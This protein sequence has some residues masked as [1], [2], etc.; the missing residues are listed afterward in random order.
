[1]IQWPFFIPKNVPFRLLR[2][3][4]PSSGGDKGGDL[5]G[6][7]S[8]CKRSTRPSTSAIRSSS[9]SIL[10]CSNI[11]FLLMAFSPLICSLQ[12]SAKLLTIMGMGNAMT[13]TPEM[14]QHVPIILPKPEIEDLNYLV[15]YFSF[16]NYYQLINYIIDFTSYT[17]YIRTV[18]PQL[19]YRTIFQKKSAQCIVF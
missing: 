1:M 19:R 8:F 12:N 16:N 7:G 6:P 9:S 18:K 14:A 2:I 15:D 11:S 10:A 4:R 3:V 13:S 17:T 5:K